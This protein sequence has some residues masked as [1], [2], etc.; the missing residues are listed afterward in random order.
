MP[1]SR[2]FA[3]RRR[4]RIDAACPKLQARARLHDT[5]LCRNRLRR[6]P[7]FCRDE[8]SP[9]HHGF[10]GAAVRGRDP[11]PQAWF[12]LEVTASQAIPTIEAPDRYGLLEMLLLL[13][14]IRAI[15]GLPEQ[16]A[17]VWPGWLVLRPSPRSRRR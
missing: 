5:I 13:W 17:C 6:L 3:R 15:A 9:P 16:L 10:G 8:G 14:A 7:G 1:G 11:L 4:S 2:R 12:L